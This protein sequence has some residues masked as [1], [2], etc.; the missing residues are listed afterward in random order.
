L[1]IRR[2]ASFWLLLPS[3][4][5]LSTLASVWQASRYLAPPRVV[6]GEVNANSSQCPEPVAENVANCG[7]VDNLPQDV[8]VEVPCLI[9]HN[10]V[11]PVRVGR[12]PPQLAR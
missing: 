3:E 12:L 1:L 8:C 6:G 7:Y 10:G 9:D 2:R 4:P 5:R 11:Q